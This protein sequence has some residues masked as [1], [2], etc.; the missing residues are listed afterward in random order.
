MKI[1]RNRQNEPR[2]R[3][4]SL[5]IRLAAVRLRLNSAKIPQII[6]NWI[7][8]AALQTNKLFGIS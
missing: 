2:R 4:V 8:R 1:P 3:M 6:E 5:E 7:V